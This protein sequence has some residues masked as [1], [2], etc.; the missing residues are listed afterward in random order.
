MSLPDGPYF[1]PSAGKSRQNFVR[2]S[3]EWSLLQLCRDRE[4]WMKSKRAAAVSTLV[5]INRAST[6]VLNA[7]VPR[8]NGKT[9]F[10]AIQ[11][12]TFG[13]PSRRIGTF[14]Q[15][16]FVCEKSKTKKITEGKSLFH[17]FYSRTREQLSWL[18]DLTFLLVIHL[19]CLSLFL[20]DFF[21]IL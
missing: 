8:L 15:P 4:I 21:G 2:S 9:V 7:L 1:F 19:C 12:A 20:L 13:E 17:L 18:L 6:T 11:H 3:V 5:A 14:T 16:F 10:N